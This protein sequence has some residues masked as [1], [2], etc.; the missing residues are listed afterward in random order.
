MV[1][2]RVHVITYPEF[3]YIYVRRE[4]IVDLDQK[5]SL[6]DDLDPYLF[7]DGIKK[8]FHTIKNILSLVDRDDQLIMIPYVGEIHWRNLII[9]YMDQN[10]TSLMNKYD[11][12]LNDSGDYCFISS[13]QYLL[14]QQIHEILDSKIKKYKRKEYLELLFDSYF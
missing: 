6:I 12:L 13:T 14:L 5:F 11:K 4:I 3:Q 10:F 9:S 2:H 1:K 8:L 7:Y